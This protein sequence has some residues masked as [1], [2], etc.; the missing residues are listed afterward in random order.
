MESIRS[1]R[2]GDLSILA[3]DNVHRWCG[4][5]CPGR[6]VQRKLKGTMSLKSSEKTAKAT[7]KKQKRGNFQEKGIISNDHDENHKAVQ[8]LECHLK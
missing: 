1:A 4:W 7:D 2:D 3:I 8:S 6:K 5:D